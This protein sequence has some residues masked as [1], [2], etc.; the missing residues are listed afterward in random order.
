M[1][2]YAWLIPLLPL[3]AA[4]WI[5][6]AYVLLGNRGEAG[7]RA[8]ARVAVGAAALSLGLAVLTGMQ[9][10]VMGPPGQVRVGS[11]LVSGDLRVDIVFTLD[12]L[13]LA[14]LL[15]VAFVALITL[16]FSVNYLHREA[17]FP[18]FFLLLSL[19]MG[20]M[21]L[22][23]MAGN[24]VL[25]FI[26]WELAGV[27]SY[28][29]IAYNFERPV[30]V[31]NAHRAFIANRI[32]DAG[33]LLGISFAYLWM[34]SSDWPLRPDQTLDPIKGDLIALA[35]LLPALA[36]SAQLPFAPWVARALEGPTPS[37]AIFYGALMVHAGVYLLIRLEPLLETT[38]AIASLIALLGALTAL[39]GWLVGLA[40][41][42]VKSSLMFST[43]AQVGLMFLWVG[44]GWYSLAAWHLA[45]HALWRAYQF[46]HAPAL[47]Q[48]ISRPARPVPAWLARRRGLQEAALQGFW[49][50]ALAD[51]FLVRPAQA[52][53]RDVM[54]LDGKV[55]SRIVG[56]PGQA[57]ELSSLGTS[58]DGEEGWLTA[59]ADETSCRGRGLL[60]RTLERVANA[61]YWFEQRLV[62]RGG[63]Q[64]LLEAIRRLGDQANQVEDLLARPRYLVL[65]ILA[66]FAV[67]L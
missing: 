40:R 10:L 59:M 52:M 38:P 49:L 17:G 27:A 7:E 20:A 28:L 13:G 4:A 19:F 47:M 60:G 39:Y 26:G 6:G 32:G 2:A 18:R 29:L 3:L 48:R 56:L 36:K 1:F 41:T 57:L 33:F 25:V 50:D 63:G 15:L 8:T 46:L 43:T 14:L 55:V 67:I 24:A 62:L 51:A 58:P 16:R 61:L 53:A 66:T 54:D 5:A 65:M 45:L 23:V 42:D 34:G 11:W 21:E 64:G 9:A 37:S 30:A 31:T 22:I 12:A 44:L 35:F